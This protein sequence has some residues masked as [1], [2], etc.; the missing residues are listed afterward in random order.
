VKEKKRKEKKE[1]GSGR[2]VWA[3]SYLFTILNIITKLFIYK[4]MMSSEQET[5]DLCS[6]YFGVKCFLENIFGI[7]QFLVGAKKMV[8]GNNFQFDRKSLFNFWKTIYGSKP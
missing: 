2:E 5:L 8:N 4:E 3:T 6:V 7:F 1:S